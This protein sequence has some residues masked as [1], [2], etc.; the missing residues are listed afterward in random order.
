MTEKFER[1]RVLQKFRENMKNSSNR[2]FS[3]FFSKTVTFTKFL[4]K[5]RENEVVLQ[6]TGS[7]CGKMRN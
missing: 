5:M 1:D 7:Q 6:V 2:L 4:P 3:N